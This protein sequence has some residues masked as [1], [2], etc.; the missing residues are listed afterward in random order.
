MLRLLRNRDLALL[1]SGQAISQ[2]GDGIFTVALAWRVYQSYSSPAA[3]SVVGIAFFV[4]RLLLTIIGGVLSDRFDRRWTMV[5][6]DVGRA[7]AVGALGAISLDPKPQL[8]AI[9]VLVAFQGI[10]GSLFGPAENALL[11]GRCLLGRLGDVFGLGGHPGPD[12]SAGTCDA[13]TR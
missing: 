3:L 10:A 5:V 7:I 4:P 8:V 1:I 12:A 11:A 2:V 9:V 13:D 6:A